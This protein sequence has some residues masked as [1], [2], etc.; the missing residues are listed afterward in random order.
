M[1]TKIAHTRRFSIHSLF[2]VS[3]AVLS[4]RCSEKVIE[5]QEKERELGYP[6]LSEPLAIFPAFNMK[7]WR[8][9][10]SSTA[11]YRRVNRKL[12]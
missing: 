6:S 8:R 9:H 1:K 12:E 10:L 3:L 4:L 7:K 11:N 2:D 5:K